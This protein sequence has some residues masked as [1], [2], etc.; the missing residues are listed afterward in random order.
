VASEQ[1]ARYTAELRRA[2]PRSDEQAEDQLL[3]QMRVRADEV[4]GAALPD[5]VTAQHVDAGGRPATR[6]VPDG[7]REDGAILHLHGGAY[8]VGAFGAHLDLAARLAAAA[9]CTVVAL[10]Y[11][12]A[13][14]H[15]HPAALE[16]A[17]AAHA[18]LVALGLPGGV[19]ISGESAGG[20]LA[21]ALLAR[22]RDSGHALPVAAA[23]LSPWADLGD[24]AAWRHPSSDEREPL[25][26]RATLAVAA[27]L[28]A[29]TTPLDDPDV[30]PARGDLRG[31]PPLFVQWGEAEMLAAD[32]RA[33]AD[34]AKLAGVE[35]T[36]DPWDRM[37]HVWQAAGGEFPEADEA[38]DRA[39]AFLA[40]R[41]AP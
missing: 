29:H 24:Q 13:P 3:E 17:G 37:W 6:I 22:L 20:G 25:L 9:R 39:G 36:T 34:R 15:P 26:R 7:A 30:S 27:R 33:L 11:R 18:W 38:V 40:A 14:E 10:D 35:V 16:D 12:L 19:A 41:L 8:A 31:L 4:I 21:L 32:A 1:F 23:L 2:G 28:Y 5:G